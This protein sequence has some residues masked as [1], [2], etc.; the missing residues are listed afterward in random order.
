MHSEWLL[1]VGSLDSTD[2]LVFSFQIDTP[3]QAQICFEFSCS[4]A[5]LDIIPQDTL[6]QTAMFYKEP[7]NH[8]YKYGTTH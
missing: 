2:G 3:S 8:S 7:I 5:D 1:I 4:P 6:K